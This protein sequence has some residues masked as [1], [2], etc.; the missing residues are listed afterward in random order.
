MAHQSLVMS[1]ATK[2][3][4]M[5]Y[6]ILKNLRANN[7]LLH[8]IG[9]Y[10]SDNYQGILWYILRERPTINYATITTVS[11]ENVNKLLD[12]HKGKVDFIICVDSN[13]TNTY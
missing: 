13:M 5:A 11:Q 8:Y 10:H 9:S 12:E 4:T 1:Q 2:D 3:A 6:F 7:T